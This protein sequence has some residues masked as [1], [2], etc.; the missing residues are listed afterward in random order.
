ML[1]AQPLRVGD[2]FH[3]PDGSLGIVYYL[4]PDGSG[5]WVVALNDA[6]GTFKWG[7]FVNIPDLEDHSDTEHPQLMYAD[8][9]GYTNTQIIRAYQGENSIYAASKVDMDNGWVLPSPAQLKILYAQQP[10][11]ENALE[12]A[13]GFVMSCDMYWS[14]AHIG[15]H[16]AAVGEQVS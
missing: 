15:E 16:H 13:G 7:A 5:G 4:H 2:V 9:A 8:T 3:A 12:A 10:F 11:I 6:P 1:T 14:S